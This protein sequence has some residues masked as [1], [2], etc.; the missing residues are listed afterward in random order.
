[1]YFITLYYEFIEQGSNYYIDVS[2]YDIYDSDSRNEEIFETAKKY[3]LNEIKQVKEKASQ[4]SNHFFVINNAYALYTV[5]QYLE[6]KN[7]WKVY[8]DILKL[9]M[10]KY[11]YITTKALFNSKYYDEIQQVFKTTQRIETGEAY[12]Y[13]N[14]FIPYLEVDYQD[15][16]NEIETIYIDK[17]GKVHENFES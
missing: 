8:E 15:Y 6:D 5:S 13:Q 10:N 7:D 14:L 16:E 9:E 17:E 1:M 4:N 12:C 2:L 11:E 3:L